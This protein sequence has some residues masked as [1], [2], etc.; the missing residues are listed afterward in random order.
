MHSFTTDKDFTCSIKF[1]YSRLKIVPLKYRWC[2]TF[3]AVYT[4]F[5]VAHIV[6]VFMLGSCFVVWSLVPFLVKQ[7]YC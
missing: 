6:C 7:S 1:L 2:L 5:A 3:D 4:L